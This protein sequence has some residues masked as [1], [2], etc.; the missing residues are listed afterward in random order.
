M[1]DPVEMET[2]ERNQNYR[3]I[4]TITKEHFNR[5]MSEQISVRTASFFII[6]LLVFLSRHQADKDQ[7]TGDKDMFEAPQQPD[8]VALVL[9]GEFAQ[10]E[11]SK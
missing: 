11:S 10:A 3:Q 4:K 5:N 1:V 9:D 7:G 6:F 8:A 2:E